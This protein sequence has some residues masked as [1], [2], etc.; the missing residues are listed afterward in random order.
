MEGRLIYGI[1]VRLGGI[2]ELRLPTPS[3]FNRHLG[4]RGARGQSGCW[5]PHV[6]P[7]GDTHSLLSG[8]T[9]VLEAKSLQTLTLTGDNPGPLLSRTVLG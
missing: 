3:P 1:K 2:C 9:H 7:T 5:Y 4:E 8:K 6:G